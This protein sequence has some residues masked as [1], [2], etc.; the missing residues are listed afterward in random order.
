ML[1]LKTVN[2]AGSGDICLA[3]EWAYSYSVSP[4]ESCVAPEQTML[5]LEKVV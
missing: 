2:N 4:E 1:A 3:P 5:G